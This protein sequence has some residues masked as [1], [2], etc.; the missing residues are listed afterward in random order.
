MSCLSLSVCVNVCGH[1]VGQL[2]TGFDMDGAQLNV[3]HTATVNHCAPL[4]SITLLSGRQW[5]RGMEEARDPS[6]PQ[7]ENIPF[8]TRAGQETRLFQQKLLCR[9]E[10]LLGHE[11]RVLGLGQALRR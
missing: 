1:P 2:P 9:E 7:P 4:F 11:Q 6:Q 8:P 3:R 5:F 10:G